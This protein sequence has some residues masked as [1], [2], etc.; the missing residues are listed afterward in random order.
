MYVSRLAL[1]AFVFFKLLFF[2]ILENI[3]LMFCCFMCEFCI[4][5]RDL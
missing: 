2:L 1:G 3:L 4:I 5:L